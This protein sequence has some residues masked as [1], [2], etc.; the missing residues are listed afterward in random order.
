MSETFTTA[1]ESIVNSSEQDLNLA[2]GALLIAQDEYPHLDPAPYL[3]R[4]DAIAEEVRARLAGES[5]PPHVVRVMNQYLFLEEEFN[6]NLADYSDPRNSYLNEVLERRL[7][8]PISLSVLYLE[9][10][11]RLGLPFEGVSFPGHF[12]VRCAHGG[13]YIVI[14][15]FFKGISLGA[16]DLRDRARRLTG[17]EMTESVL[18]SWLAS[19]SKRSILLRML[20]NLKAIFLGKGAYDRALAVIERMVLLAPDAAGEIRDRGH[21]YRALECFRP[22]LADYVRYLELAPDAEDAT[23]I[24][25]AVMELEKAAAKIN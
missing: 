18:S 16:E 17:E 12:L 8:I 24:R 4:L 6:G 7:G 5:D 11:W 21:A 25:L 19:V 1:F 15:P 2:E 9:V 22:A 13:G 14:D 23:E 10:A 3:A 20:R